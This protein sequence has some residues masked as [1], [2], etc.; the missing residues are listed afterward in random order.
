[1]RMTLQQKHFS[2]HTNCEK[3]VWLWTTVPS[4]TC[5]QTVPQGD[6]AF[7][8]LMGHLWTC[9]SVDPIASSVSKSQQ[10]PIYASIQLL[11]L[12][13]PNILS[14]LLDSLPRDGAAFQRSN[15]IIGEHTLVTQLLQLPKLPS[16]IQLSL[17][18]H[19]KLRHVNMFVT[20]SAHRHLRCAHKELM[21]YYILIHSFLPSDPSKVITC[22]NSSAIRRANLMFHNLWER[23]QKP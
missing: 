17:S 6:N 18:K 9:I 12:P 2:P 10:L 16:K 5:A 19:W 11:N 4:T 7:L 15:Y 20:T 1:M 14:Q 21:I 23:K 3:R 8:F 13:Y 22:S